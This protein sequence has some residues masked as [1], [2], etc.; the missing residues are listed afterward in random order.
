MSM[1]EYRGR[2]SDE[3][4][5]EQRRVKVELLGPHACLRSCLKPLR[6]R[7]TMDSSANIASATDP[8][9]G[10]EER[11]LRAEEKNEQ[12]L[13]ER[14]AMERGQ[15]SIFPRH[16]RNNV[17]VRE[18]EG[19]VATLP[20]HSHCPAQTQDDIPPTSF[21]DLAAFHINVGLGTGYDEGDGNTFPDHG[22]LE[23]REMTECMQRSP[24]L[25]LK[26]TPHTP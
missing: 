2:G 20:R 14:S 22:P 23:I 16:F 7:K 24:M 3:S 26:P 12:R 8:L 15:A 19:L 13:D 10:Q 5:K 6:E 18:L 1:G 11:L 4:G 21:L 25:H 17:D 9:D